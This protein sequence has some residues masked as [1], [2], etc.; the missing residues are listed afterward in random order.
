MILHKEITYTK[1]QLQNEKSPFK[2]KMMSIE[3][4]ELLAETDTLITLQQ[5]LK[6]KEMRIKIIS[7]LKFCT[8]MIEYREKELELEE[9]REARERYDKQFAEGKA[10]RQENM[11]LQH[12]KGELAL[13][14]L[15]EKHPNVYSEVTD[16]L[17]TIFKQP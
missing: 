10:R 2:L 9:K 12:S 13:K 15:K 8:V 17:Q 14:F 3:L 7:L 4:S 16:Y 6:L 1:E 5:G 11:K